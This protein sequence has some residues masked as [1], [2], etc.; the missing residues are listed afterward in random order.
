MRTPYPCIVYLHASGCSRVEAVQY[1][2]VIVSS[3]YS[4][5]CFDFSGSGKSKGNYVSV[6]WFEQDDLACVID[7]LSSI[8]YVSNI[9]LW[10]R[11]MGAIATIF[12]VSKNPQ[13]DCIVLDS[14]FSNFKTFIQEFVKN[15]ISIPAFLTNSI[16]SIINRTVQKKAGF[17][18]TELVP[19]E[20]I[21]KSKIPALFGV[22]KEDN[23]IPSQHT[24]DLHQAYRGP[25]ELCIFEGNHN[26]TRPIIWLRQVLNFFNQYLKQ[27]K[28]NS[29][30]QYLNYH[31]RNEIKSSQIN[32][33]TCKENI[34]PNV[35][36]KFYHKSMGHIEISQ[37]KP[38]PINIKM[39]YDIPKPIKTPPSIIPDENIPRK[40]FQ[41]REIQ[42]KGKFVNT[43][44]YNSIIDTE[45]DKDAVNSHN[46]IPLFKKKFENLISQQ[47]T[48]EDQSNQ[49]HNSQF[50][51]NSKDEVCK[52]EKSLEFPS[53]NKIRNSN[54][55]F[56]QKKFRK[57]IEDRDTHNPFRIER[58]RPE[59]YFRHENIGKD[60]NPEL[61]LSF[62][63]PKIIDEQQRY[64]T[65]FTQDIETLMAFPPK[66]PTRFER[67]NKG[68]SISQENTYRISKSSM[69]QDKILI[70]KGRTNCS[71]FSLKHSSLIQS[72]HSMKERGN[73]N[74]F[75]NSYRHYKSNYNQS[76]LL[77][78]ELY[79]KSNKKNIYSSFQSSKSSRETVLHERSNW[80]D[81]S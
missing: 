22:G 61:N 65:N 1:I 31:W 5:F 21:N 66:K 34:K 19:F 24:I 43:T 30:I 73:S 6:G 12:Y 40:P 67:Q 46:I 20:Y 13:I 72:L 68:N 81:Q 33:S 75:S 41:S 18:L 16:L 54:F 29:E 35:S 44:N 25:K 76:V 60:K 71:E 77:T 42:S 37:N 17:D 52:I 62:C 28:S 2:D 4:F 79:A 70:I 58:K 3:G 49:F 51:T 11:S 69:N 15:K 9:G 27:S 7:Y 53:R 57:I 48:N 23:F 36:K 78:E 74:L 50:L 55:S 32:K 39:N 26:S 63:F 80:V 64:S 8:K 14:P 10:G 45:L 47:K 38:A 56:S 59:Y